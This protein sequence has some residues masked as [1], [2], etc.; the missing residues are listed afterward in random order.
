MLGPRTRE[1]LASARDAGL[2]VVVVTSRMFRSVLPYVAEAGL[3]TPVVCY[4]AP[5][6]PIP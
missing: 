3:T 4:Q 6:W 1:A 5:S 2:H